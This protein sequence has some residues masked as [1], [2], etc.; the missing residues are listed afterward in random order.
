MLR[1]ASNNRRRTSLPLKSKKSKISRQKPLVV[2]PKSSSSE[3]EPVVEEEP[4][5]EDKLDMEDDSD[6]SDT[7]KA[8]IRELTA[9]AG[10]STI[11]GSALARAV[12]QSSSS[13]LEQAHQ[14]ANKGFRPVTQTRPGTQTRT[15]GKAK[16]KAPEPT[17]RHEISCVAIY[18]Y[19]V[20]DAD[21]DNDDSVKALSRLEASIGTIRNLCDM[22]LCIESTPASPLHL[23]P[24]WTVKEVD[25]QLVKWLPLPMSYL[26]EESIFRP[27]KNPRYPKY[28]GK[29]RFLPELYLCERVRGSI[30]PLSGPSVIFPNGELL[31]QTAGDNGKSGV[32]R[33]KLIFVT[34][35]PMPK[36][37][38]DFFRAVVQEA[39]KHDVSLLAAKYLVRASQEETDDDMDNDHSQ[40][41]VKDQV[42]SDED[43]N[44]PTEVD[45]DADKVGPSK[46]AKR[47]R[48]LVGEEPDREPPKKIRKSTSNCRNPIVVSSGDDS[49][50]NSVTAGSSSSRLRLRPR[51]IRP[52]TAV[53]PAPAALDEPAPSPPKPDFLR[54]YIGPEPS[55]ENL[56]PWNGIP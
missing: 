27:E 13:K 43:D 32:S 40:G 16:A 12:K 3:D 41:N 54:Y 15:K 42:N 50:T 22:G 53:P 37:T 8:A 11:S 2:K 19:G 39:K 31:W 56:D 23:D 10:T 38:L 24:T 35:K 7:V 48:L 45:S 18:P 14:E 17:E 44:V 21:S 33:R 1:P 47:V 28:D 49:D 36:K 55:L 46:P 6:M 30:K 29:N 9:K 4:V 51:P 25:R 52:A 5:V 20:E 34:R 26:N